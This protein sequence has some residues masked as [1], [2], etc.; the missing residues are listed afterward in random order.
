LTLSATGLASVLVM[1]GFSQG[2]GDLSI[3]SLP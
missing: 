1:A 3:T 2:I